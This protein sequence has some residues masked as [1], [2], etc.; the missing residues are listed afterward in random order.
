MSDFRC[1]LLG[2]TPLAVIGIGVNISLMTKWPTN[3]D[4]TCECAV[5][6]SAESEIASIL[7]L[8]LPIFMGIYFQNK[9]L[10]S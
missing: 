9:T 5:E 7:R 1:F 4:T 3:D 6:F 2:T 10:V 8:L